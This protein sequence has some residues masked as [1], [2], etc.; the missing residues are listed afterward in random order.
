MGLVPDMSRLVEFCD[1]GRK[2]RAESIGQRAK[3]REHRAKS[4]GVFRS[5]AEI[6]TN[7]WL[8]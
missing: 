6:P 3:S 4:R 2:Q 5:A 7:A 1:K 8:L